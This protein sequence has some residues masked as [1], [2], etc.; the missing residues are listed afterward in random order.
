MS[1]NLNESLAL[2]V[3]LELYEAE[4]SKNEI[5]AGFYHSFDVDVASVGLILNL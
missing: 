4:L 5:G 3:K 2:R 1:F